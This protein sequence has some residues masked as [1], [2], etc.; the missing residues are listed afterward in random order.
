PT[1]AGTPPPLGPFTETTPVDTE[2]ELVATNR[3]GQVTAR[4]KIRLR[5]WPKLAIEGLEVTQGIQ[6]F[7][8]P[9]VAWNS[10]ATV[11]GKDTIVR[12]YVSVAMGGFMG[13]QLPQGTGTLNVGGP[14]RYPM[15]GTAP[16]GGAA[17]PFITAKAKASINR[18]QTND[19]LNF[20]IPAA[21]A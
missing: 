11:A 13:D 15:N 20:R 10:L 16:T 8:R 3:C 18:T 5:K 9:G 17:N 6:V 12:V 1:P 19:T 2:Y 7:W 21:L 14:V 4:V